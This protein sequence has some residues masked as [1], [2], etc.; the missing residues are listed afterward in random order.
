MP[1]DSDYAAM[2]YGRGDRS[3]R[4]VRL[5]QEAIK[6]ESECICTNAESWGYTC[7]VHKTKCRAKS[8]NEE[9]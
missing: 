7:P 2:A 3:D 6:N 1:S 5:V 8:D 4:T 9:I